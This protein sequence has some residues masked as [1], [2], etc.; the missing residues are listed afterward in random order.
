MSRSSKNLNP[1]VFC[2]KEIPTRSKYYEFKRCYHLEG[3]FGKCQE[4]PFLNDLQKTHP[5]V[6]K[7]IERDSIMTTG[8]S[9]KS[10]EAGPNRILRWVMLEDDE[11]LLEYG[12]DMSK[13]KPQVIAKLR[14]KSADYDSCIKVAMWLTHQ[15]YQMESAPKPSREISHYLQDYFGKIKANSSTCTICKELLSFNLFAKAKRGKAEIETCH[16]NPRL[17][18]PDNVGFAHRFCNIAQG[19]K[20]LDEFYQWIAGILTRVNID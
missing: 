19:G 3:H 6:A 11:K 2:Q 7:K 1:V 12:L 14:E 5:N 4:M 15:A 13:L 17:H 9:W 8:A 18:S 20:T 16:K 10:E